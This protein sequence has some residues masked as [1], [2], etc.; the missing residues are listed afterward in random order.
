MKKPTG[1]VL[2]LLLVVSVGMGIWYMTKKRPLPVEIASIEENVEI[3]VFGLGTVEARILSKIGF[4]MSNT[5]VELNA[6]EGD[7]VRKGAVLA[8]LDSTEQQARLSKARAG[9]LSADAAVK[10]AQSTILKAKAIVATKEGTN[11]RKQTLF[12]KH[13]ISSESAEAA[14]LDLDT[15]QAELGIA[16][17]SL[18]TAKAALKTAQ[19]QL[20]LEEVTLNQY[21][22]KAPYDAVVTARH[23]ELGTV[24]KAGEPLF[25]LV[26]P[27]TVWV[28]GYIS[29]SRSGLIRLDQVAEIRLRSRPHTLY[30]GK[31]QR[32]DIESD[33]VTEER[34]V[35][36]SCEECLEQFNLGEQA[37][38]Y[39]TTAILDKALFIPENA[40]DNFDERQMKGTVWI[41]ES[42]KLK[43]QDVTFGHR[44]LDA[45]LTIMGGLSDDAK[46]L[47]KLPKL[48]KE[49]RS[50]KVRGGGSS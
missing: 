22:L 43:K 16:Q 34:R 4:R 50:T 46:V 15:A 48:L 38:V 39:V 27:K 25:T 17:S 33:R 23:M 8:R 35:Y 20:E 19:A 37:E 47:K 31:V 42:G 49:G 26:D 21:V 44:T 3:K 12:K 13:T 14:K 9:V 36:L 1:K 5:I 28:L 11:N 32:I 24:V 29:E 6:D 7:N 2:I 10:G 40:V 18:L 30:R 45:R 41:L